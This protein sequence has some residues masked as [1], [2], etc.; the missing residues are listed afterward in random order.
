MGMILFMLLP[1]AGM[2]YTGWHVWV[3]L[4][5][6]TLWRS[7]VVGF[8]VL[9][10]LLLFANF[11]GLLERLPLPV[12]RVSYAL[13]TS[14]VIVLLYLVMAFL[15]LDLGR[16]V[17][18]VPRS[19]LYSNGVAAV[20][21]TGFMVTLLLCG[22]VHY[23]DKQRV[24]LTL[25]T[26]KALPRSYR[27]LMLS[28]LHLGYHNTRSDLAR[29]V[30][31]I[32]GEQPDAILIAGDIVDISV[33]PLLKDSMAA[34]FHRLK[35]PVYASLG[36]H[37]YYADPERAR[38]FF[39]A[40]GITLL[41]DST[42]IF[43]GAI[44]IIGRDDQSNRRRK[45]V[46]ELVATLNSK[47]SPLNSKLSTLNSPPYTILLDHQ[48][49]HLELAEQAGIDFQLSGHTHRGQVWPV[50]WITDAL[51]ECSWGEHQRG[52]TRYYVSSGLGIWGGKFRI[53]TQSEYVVA[54]L[55][56]LQ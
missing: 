48:P 55:K 25:T 5:F 53:G 40:A 18:I 10:F 54:T 16:L 36:N 46:A 4:P 14:S 12:A 17:H 28:D 21:L 7:V 49:Y 32:N 24:E 33:A 42:A 9:C 29:W 56:K 34:E 2:A 44:A 19:W 38:H 11:G 31:M 52:S 43:D 13:G 8:G 20:A 50:S 30:D 27:L 23:Y 26:T 22:R 41:R 37:E 1:I 45:S 3:L 51:Y 15:V 47:L 39:D 6:S 35:A